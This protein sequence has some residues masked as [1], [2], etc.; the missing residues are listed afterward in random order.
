MQ[1]VKPLHETTAGRKLRTAAWS[2]AALA[3]LAALIAVGLRFGGDT[4]PPDSIVKPQ[5]TLRVIDIVIAS[6]NQVTLGTNTLSL[7]AATNLLARYSTTVDVVALHGPFETDG[8]LMKTSSV[9]LAI[10]RAGVPLVFVE[11]D[12]EFAWREQAAEDGIRTVTIGT[13]QV[14]ALRRLWSKNPYGAPSST[15]VLKTSI[16]WD[17]AEGTY[18]L[19]RIEVGLLGERVWLMH[20][21]SQD[22]NESGTIGIQFRKEW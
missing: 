7:A 20:E 15:P 6:T 9:A 11:K 10:A 8:L 22:D 2:L 14:A 12:G 21:Q 18:E 13:D 5:E 3:A 1:P 19:K 16:D 17:P 4:E